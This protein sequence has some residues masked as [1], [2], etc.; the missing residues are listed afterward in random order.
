[1]EHLLMMVTMVH[2]T[3]YSGQSRWVADLSNAQPE[4]ST[5]TLME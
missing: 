3:N 2:Y 4:Q 5:N 1:M